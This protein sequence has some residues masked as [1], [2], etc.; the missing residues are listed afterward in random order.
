MP[1]SDSGWNSF[2]LLHLSACLSVTVLSDYLSQLAP[3]GHPHWKRP[4]FHSTTASVR[5]TGRG[6]GRPQSHQLQNSPDSDWCNQS[7]S[8]LQS[9]WST[10]N[11]ILR[12]T[13]EH[14]SA[15]WPNKCSNVRTERS[16]QPS[17]SPWFFF[18]HKNW[19]TFGPSADGCEH[20]VACTLRQTPW[21]TATARQNK[22]LYGYLV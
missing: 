10:G 13:K 16:V 14:S 4:L 22:L 18:S 19:I 17:K 12:V 8:T 11:E 1:Q 15:Q 5:E 21:Q 2:S 6:R 20:P 7:K 3:R 9:T